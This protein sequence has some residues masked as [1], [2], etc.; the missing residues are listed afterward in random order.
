MSLVDEHVYRDVLRLRFHFVCAP[1]IRPLQ[2]VVHIGDLQVHSFRESI[3]F[4]VRNSLLAA[5]YFNGGR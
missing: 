2:I 3:G 4:A 1:I 5:E